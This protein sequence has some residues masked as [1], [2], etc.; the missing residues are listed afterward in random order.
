MANDNKGQVT[1]DIKLEMDYWEKEKLMFCLK[2]NGLDLQTWM[3][4]TID[5]L[6]NSDPELDREWEVFKSVLE[7]RQ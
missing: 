3:L 2:E 7:Q 1:L 4:A 6:L 5:E